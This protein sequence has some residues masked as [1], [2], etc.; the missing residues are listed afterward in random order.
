MAP[1]T[2]NASRS[3]VTR[4]ALHGITVG[5]TLHRRKVSA[6]L[7]PSTGRVSG[8]GPF[9]AT[10]NHLG[11]NRVAIDSLRSLFSLETINPLLRRHMI[12]ISDIKGSLPA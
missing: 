4:V 12:H 6:S 10:P 11:R 3:I 2:V 8:L 7:H 9:R 1:T 5:R